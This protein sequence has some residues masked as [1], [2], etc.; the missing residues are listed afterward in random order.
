MNTDNA[1]SSPPV[2]GSLFASH[3]ND[4]NRPEEVGYRQLSL[5][6]IVAFVVGLLSFSAFLTIWLLPVGLFGIIAALI[7]LSAIRRSDGLL[8]GTWFAQIG[9]SLSIITTIAVAAFWPYYQ[10]RIRCEADAFCRIWLD[11]VRRHDMPV[12]LM[13]TVPFWDRTPDPHDSEA[14]WTAMPNNRHL[15]NEMQKLVRN[16]LLRT[17]MAFGES[18]EITYYATDRIITEPDYDIAIMIYA[19][20][21]PAASGG[22]ETFFVRLMSKRRIYYKDRRSVGWNLESIPV[23]LFVPPAFKK[24][25]GK[26]GA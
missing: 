1:E 18:A 15:H 12:V 3:W 25:D 19:V 26:S 9:L 11:A 2:S 22:K 6:A 20:T 5:W 14:W 17:I 10:Y 23:E 24:A 16:P 7:A 21:V 8:V 13:G 4:T